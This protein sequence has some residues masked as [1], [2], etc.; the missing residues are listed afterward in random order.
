[1]KNGKLGLRMSRS[2]YDHIHQYEAIN[3]AK[4]VYRCIVPNCVHLI[5]RNIMIGRKAQCPACSATIVITRNDLENKTIAC[6][7]HKPNSPI[8]NKTVIVEPNTGIT[9]EQILA[10]MKK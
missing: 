2:N 9:L 10:G 8:P 3:T 7:G 4:K 6:K 1:M 5:N